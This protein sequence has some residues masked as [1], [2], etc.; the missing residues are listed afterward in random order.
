MKQ[1]GADAAPSGEECFRSALDWARG[2]NVLSWELRVATS[3]ARLWHDQG[4]S[5]D[6]R[7]LLSSTYRRFSEGFSTI[8]LRAAKAL[9]DKLT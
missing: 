1:V 2:R 4:R 7:E 3:Y 9:L 5:S 8:D 6:A